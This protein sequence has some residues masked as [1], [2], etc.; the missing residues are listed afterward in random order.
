VRFCTETFA[1]EPKRGADLE[2]VR[3]RLEEISATAGLAAEALDGGAVDLM[4]AEVER[5]VMQ[6]MGD[7]GCRPG[8]IFQRPAFGGKWRRPLS[9]S[10]AHEKGRRPLGK[11]AGLMEDA[12]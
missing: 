4:P 8:V 2:H 7:P 3:T 6:L 11:D 12:H 9:S 1:A 5:F 10:R